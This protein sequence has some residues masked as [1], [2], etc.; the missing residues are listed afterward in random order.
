MRIATWNI[1]GWGSKGKKNTV[2]NLIKEESIELIGLV[3]TKHSDVSQ[4]DMM[5]CWGKQDTDWVHIPAT[6]SSRGLILTWHKESFVAVN[7]FLG[8]RWISVQ[9]VF[10]N[11]NFR[12]AVC[13]VYA[14]ND[15]RGRMTVWDQLR[16]LKQHLRLPLLIMGDFNEVVT[17]DERKGEMQFTS[18]MRELGDLV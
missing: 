7:T 18:R 14:P 6:N 11:D 12:C 10:E 8:Q 13:V 17:I 3:E 5:R 15:Q 2:K 1:R 9:G 16:Y 4:W